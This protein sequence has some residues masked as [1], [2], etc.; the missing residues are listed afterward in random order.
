MSN[1]RIEGTLGRLLV[2]SACF[3]RVVVGPTTWAL[4]AL[5]FC[6]AGS[7]RAAIESD[8]RD[9]TTPSD[10]GRGDSDE[11]SRGGTERDSA[12]AP[13]A[14]V[15]PGTAVSAGAVSPGTSEAPDQ[16][17]DE[18]GASGSNDGTT[19]DPNDGG[20]PA[21]ESGFV[22]EEVFLA[23]L[24][25]VEPDPIDISV[26]PE[27]PA[28]AVQLARFIWRDAPDATTVDLARR[29]KL[30]LP[31]DVYA[32]AQRLLAD[33]RSERGFESF[34]GAWTEATRSKELVNVAVDDAG[35][36]RASDYVAALNTELYAG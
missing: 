11:G 21:D 30:E 19:D 17:S 10:T 8:A 16:L 29:G 4:C 6:V 32:E 2:Q 9:R 35:V 23:T 25:V 28:I 31:S 22:P 27:T 1:R 33:P 20:P 36:S 3:G 18:S 13:G 24:P 34:F 12:V 5:L 15:S 7:D 14:A 26:S